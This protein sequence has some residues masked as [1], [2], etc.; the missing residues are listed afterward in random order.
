M[1]GRND[2]LIEQGIADG[3]FFF[4]PLREALPDWRRA[5]LR[6]SGASGI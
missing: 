3:A 2:L 6:T 4:A 1:T 5:Y